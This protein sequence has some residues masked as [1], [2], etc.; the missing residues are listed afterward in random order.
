M[1][2]PGPGVPRKSGS[3]Q[4]IYSWHRSD[5]RSTISTPSLRAFA[6]G[7]SMNETSPCTAAFLDKLYSKKQSLL[8]NCGGFQVCSHTRV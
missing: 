5:F 3:D 4:V 6:T 7:K 2:W 1:G 8:I